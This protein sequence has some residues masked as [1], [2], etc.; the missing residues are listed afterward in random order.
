MENGASKIHP[1]SVKH[2][3]ISPLLSLFAS[4]LSSFLPFGWEW[5]IK[6][7]EWNGCTLTLFLRQQLL[8]VI[9][10]EGGGICAPFWPPPKGP[11]PS[12]RA[13][14]A[15]ERINI[16]DYQ[17]RGSRN[18]ADGQTDTDS[19]AAARN[20]QVSVQRQKRLARARPMVRVRGCPS[21]HRSGI[22]SATDGRGVGVL[23]GRVMRDEKKICNNKCGI[24]GYAFAPGRPLGRPLTEATKYKFAD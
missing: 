19:A 14:R 21:C 13:G 4:P 23:Y 24:C 7:P 18:T 16:S 20:A 9:I 10:R 15:S 1:I 8:S 2:D 12:H 17:R 5:E 6:F 11:R 3:A 22:G